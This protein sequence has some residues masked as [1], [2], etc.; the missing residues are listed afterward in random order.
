MIALPF[1]TTKQLARFLAPENPAD[2][3]LRGKLACVVRLLRSLAEEEQLHAISVA[4]TQMQARRE[5]V[6]T[7]RTSTSRNDEKAESVS[8][9]ALTVNHDSGRH[10]SIH[11]CDSDT[12]ADD[13]CEAAP[14]LAR[15]FEVT[16]RKTPI[17][18]PLLRLT[19]LEELGS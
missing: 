9:R 1:D 15:P 13:S 16:W 12:N 14:A 17:G 2:Y 7:T 10:F 5:P 4:E 3:G 8:M 18:D 19:A 6:A 11:K